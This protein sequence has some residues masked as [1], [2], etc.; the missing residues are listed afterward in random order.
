VHFRSHYSLFLTIERQ[1]NVNMK[2]RTKRSP[3]GPAPKTPSPK[4]STGKSNDADDSPTSVAAPPIV[5][6]V[7]VDADD[8]EVTNAPTVAEAS[9]VVHQADDSKVSGSNDPSTLRSE[10]DALRS[11]SDDKSIMAVLRTVPSSF[12]V[13]DPPKESMAFVVYA[14]FAYFSPV[15]MRVIRTALLWYRHEAQH[16]TEA[17]WPKENIFVVVC[18]STD[19]MMSHHFISDGAVR[20]VSIDDV[21]EPINKYPGVDEAPTGGSDVITVSAAAIR[22]VTSSTAGFDGTAGSL[23]SELLSPPNRYVSLI[24]EH[25]PFLLIVDNPM[26]QLISFPDYCISLQLMNSL[27]VAPALRSMAAMALVA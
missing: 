15:V 16:H 20:F 1:R 8:G 21:Y 4:R 25:L 5:A 7:A 3:S 2:T 6:G 11:S 9:V 27:Q 10:F 22:D 14:A 13:F 17:N 26:L 23:R 12:N 19:D 18:N 24:I